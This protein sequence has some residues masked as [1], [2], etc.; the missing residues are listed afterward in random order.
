MG[1]GQLGPWGCEEVGRGRVSARERICASAPDTAHDRTP[2][3]V[4]HPL[5]L[6]PPWSGRHAAIP[7]VKVWP[8]TPYPLGAT[9]DGAGTNFS[10]FSE[11]ATR[12]ELCFFD[13]DGK[14]SCVDLPEMTGFIWHG[15]V[16]NIGPGQ[17]YGFRVHGPWEPGA[18]H[19]CNPAKLLLDPYGKAV[20]GQVQWN[21]A[22]FGHFFDDPDAKNDADSAPF[23]PKSVVTNPYFDWVE[24]PLSAHAVARDDHLRGPRQ[25]LH[26]AASRGAGES[27]RD[28]RGAR[29]SGRDQASEDARRHRGR[30]PARP[31]VHPRLAAARARAAQ[32]LGL[33]LHQLSRRAQRVLVGRPDAGSRCRSSSR[34]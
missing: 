2:S 1:G 12:V 31:S 22:V 17:R 14:Q 6:A 3:P 5:P 23:M 10:V 26:A 20:D 33:Q 24:R 34:W 25:R 32:L 4:A 7:T 8:G 13:D 30:A 16:P 15:Y 28:V 29:A 27:A 11:V 19:R 18:G 9:Y 21:E